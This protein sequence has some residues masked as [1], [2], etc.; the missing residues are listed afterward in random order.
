M[1]FT[2]HT[3]E[4]VREMLQVCGVSSIEAL[5]ADIPASLRTASFN[6]PP[7]RTEQEITGT[8]A[9][10]I[11]HTAVHSRS[12]IGAGYYD[13]FIPA[14]VD[15]LANRSEF[16]TAY[17]P[18]QPECAQGT[19][20]ALFEYQTA[21]CRLTGMDA[22]NASLYD[23][24]SALAEAGMM[25]LRIT[26]RNKVVVTG[27]VN[28]LHRRILETYFRTLGS[29]VVTVPAK[30]HAPDLAALAAAIDD[31]TAAVLV[32]NPD[33]YGGI[34]D[35][36][37]LADLAHKTGALLVMSCYPIAL[38]MLKTPAEHG[39]DIAVGDGQSLGNPLSFGG[40]YLGYIATRRQY[41][42]QLPGRIIG[43]TVDTQG[44]RGFVLTLQ[45]REQHIRRE[46]ATSNICSN[47]SL[48]AL[49][50]VIYL[51]LLGKQGFVELAERLYRTTAYARQQF[52][53]AGFPL[54]QT[55]PVFNEF[56]VTLPRP[57]ARVVSRLHLVSQ[58]SVGLPLAA[59]SAGTEHDLL[60]SFTEQHDRADIDTL[61]AALAEQAAKA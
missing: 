10:W 33:F 53:A 12:F 1:Q 35:F 34:H 49:R 8:A 38:G 48:C 13:H 46:K 40:P 22:A 31:K 29:D 57:A 60:V 25:A 17:T 21:I 20:Q 14:A 43:E 7:G 51:S 4:E 45:A 28:P 19:L 23:G 15:A 55:G 50:A 3:P 37:P 47:Q 56:V 9:A 42:R 36:A 58:L 61:I 44:R 24:G 41:I 16:V 6:L 52:Q 39:A 32:Q 59:L 11:S 2:P 18:Y 54:P 30:N 26:K 5:F 27:D